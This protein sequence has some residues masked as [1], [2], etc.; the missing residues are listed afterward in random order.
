[1]LFGYRMQCVITNIVRIEGPR[2]RK[3]IE[4]HFENF[5]FKTYF[6]GE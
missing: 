1:M 5:Q 2:N 6:G 4:K 3:K